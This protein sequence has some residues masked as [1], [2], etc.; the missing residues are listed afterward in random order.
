MKGDMEYDKN[1]ISGG[2][3][4]LDWYSKLNDMFSTAGYNKPLKCLLLMM[5]MRFKN[6]VMKLNHAHF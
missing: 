5:L 3:D 2:I 4:V 6:C 1:Y